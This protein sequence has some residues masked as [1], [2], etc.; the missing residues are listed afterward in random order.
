LGTRK[1][2]LNLT[3]GTEYATPT[4]TRNEVRKKVV[5]EAKYPKRSDIPI[6]MIDAVDATLLLTSPLGMGRSG[7]LIR[8]FSRSKTSFNMY[9]PAVAQNIVRSACTADDRSTAPEKPTNKPARPAI[10]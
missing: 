6:R 1:N 9:I 2:L 10:A 7:S 4:K 3:G 5:T 8:S